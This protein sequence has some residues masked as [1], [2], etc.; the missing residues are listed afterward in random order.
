MMHAH[1]QNELLTSFK[2]LY[3]PSRQHFRAIQQLQFSIPLANN[4]IFP[5][6]WDYVQ[7]LKVALSV[8]TWRGTCLHR[9]KHES[10]QARADLGSQEMKSWFL[11]VDLPPT[12]CEASSTPFISSPDV[13]HIHTHLEGTILVL[14]SKKIKNLFTRSSYRF[15]ALLSSGLL[16]PNPI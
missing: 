8:V 4:W 10:R 14:R 13:Q 9:W 2:L 6:C 3:T 7:W 15:P 12:L 5:N 11:G 16:S 1:T